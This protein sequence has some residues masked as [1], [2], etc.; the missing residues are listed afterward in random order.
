MEDDTTSPADP[1]RPIRRFL[2]LFR[3][4]GTSMG[5]I[6]AATPVLTT[7]LDLV[8]L[9]HA[10]RNMLTFFGSFTAVLAAAVLF[11]YRHQ[12][13]AAVFPATRR[14]LLPSE[15]SSRQLFSIWVPVGLAA[16]S[17]GSL[18]F[19]QALTH[20]SV[21]RVVLE[22]AVPEA[23]RRDVGD[24]PPS[25]GARVGESSLGERLLSGYEDLAA[26]TRRSVAAVLPWEAGD[27][28]EGGALEVLGTV[29]KLADGADP[30]VSVRFLSERGVRLVLDN[31]P[32]LNIPYRWGILL[33]YV[34]MFAF[35]T[36]A[37]VWLGLMEFAQ[38]R[39]GLED[40]ELM[41]SPFRAADRHQFQLPG[42]RVVS[43]S[44]V[45]GELDPSRNLSFLMYLRI[46]GGKVDLLRGPVG[47]ICD[48]HD[49]PLEPVGLGPAETRWRCR[50]R[51]S[52]D[53]K[54]AEHELVLAAEGKGDAGPEAISNYA[55]LRDALEL[56]TGE[57]ASLRRLYERPEAGEPGGPEAGGET[58]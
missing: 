52:D 16:L 36:A 45:E 23:E 55:V 3:S 49:Q 57:L 15:M 31:T 5:A 17:L 47:P 10:D 53:R 38:E 37:F 42:R 40:W 32:S 12:I 48:R 4:Y 9:Y 27:G 2:A 22:Y 30:R 11:S 41:S 50:Y 29:E 21:E 33:S 6:V 34:L 20:Y 56:A 43:D 25:W 46:A 39:L 13:G 7:V 51:T 24:P 1:Q 58:S 19:W 8:P 26:A 18:V 54:P 14:I 35:G 44:D 28:G